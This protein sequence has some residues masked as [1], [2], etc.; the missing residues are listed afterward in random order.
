MS[1]SSGEDYYPLR[2]FY[3]VHDVVE[4]GDMENLRTML[5]P[6]RSKSTRM[7]DGDDYAANGNDVKDVR[8]ED[9]FDPSLPHLDLEEKDR[10][11]ATPLHVAIMSR[12]LE[13]VRLLLEAGVIPGKRLEGST[14]AHI[15]LSLGSVGQHRHFAHEALK[16]LLA[17]RADA[18]AKDDRSRTLLHL[19]ADLGLEDC[20]TTVL[21]APGGAEILDAKER[22]HYRPLHLAALR[23]HVGILN[24]LIEAGCDT[25][26]ISMHGYTALH[27][28]CSK[29]HWAAARLV[30]LATLQSDT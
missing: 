12:Q 14:P 6:R 7:E 29:A 21:A 27:M 3:P 20:A 2:R 17:H 10:E 5:A 1:S 23:G 24:V 25:S 9:D 19:A 28:A 13:C 22:L 16:L 30:F 4:D 8:E 26:S 15:A 18:T 11:G